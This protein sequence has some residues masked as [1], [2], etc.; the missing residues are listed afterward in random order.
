MLGNCKYRLCFV[1]LAVL[2]F[3]VLF[4]DARGNMLMSVV[5]YESKVG[6]K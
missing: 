4:L 5:I 3:L 2:L 6:K 1:T